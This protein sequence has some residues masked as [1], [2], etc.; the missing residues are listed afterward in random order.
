MGQKIVL[1][2]DAPEPAIDAGCLGGSAGLLGQLVN[3]VRLTL[4]VIDVHGHCGDK[5]ADPGRANP[6]DLMW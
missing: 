3:C 5:H 4:P 2:R 6:A 1:S